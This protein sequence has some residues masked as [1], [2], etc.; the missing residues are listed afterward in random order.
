M[1]AGIVAR[2]RVA[3]LPLA[4]ASAWLVGAIVRGWYVFVAHDPRQFA[5]SDMGL[6][7]AVARRF[8]EPAAALGPGDVT[9]PPG[10]SWLLSRLLLFDPTLLSA[11]IYLSTVSVLAPFAMMALARQCGGRRAAWI[12][13]AAGS[14]YYPFIAY[15]GF[16]LAETTMIL[17]V[18]AIVS[19]I[20]AALRASDSSRAT[21]AAAA[22]G[23]LISIALT[24]KSVAL[25]VFAFTWLVALLFRRMERRRRLLLAAAVIA[26]VLPLIVASSLK[27]TQWNAGRPCIAG[28][29]WGADVLLG[30]YGQVKAIRWTD[31]HFGNPAAKERGY[32]ETAVVSVSMTDSS[33][34]LA[35][36]GEW[37]AAHPVEALALSLLHVRDTFG[38]HAPW[39]M[40][41]ADGWGIATIFALLY[42]ILLLLPALFVAATGVASR[43][44]ASFLRTDTALLLAPLAAL[45]VVVFASV[46][47]SRYRVPFD[48][49]LM[50]IV[51]GAI[52]R[53]REAR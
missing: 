49:L 7:L 30:H 8:A 34:N 9:H 51:A 5:V 12:V 43:G 11:S 18:P 52:V 10:W 24:F 29:K 19:L 38:G 33:A 45:A 26:G 3:V 41:L 14:L 25:P 20:V 6:Y 42:V 21:L 17:L 32:D 53:N 2:G 15:S 1:T 28:N 47:E 37:I 50:V 4:A 44:A 35:L 40:S 36:A 13:L 22:S 31:F 39:P 48:S 27:C 46:G 23:V 16:L